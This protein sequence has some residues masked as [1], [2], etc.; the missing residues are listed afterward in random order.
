MDNPTLEDRAELITHL[1]R[2]WQSNPGSYWSALKRSGLTAQEVWPRDARAFV[3]TPLPRSE[4][5]TLG[6]RKNAGREE[7]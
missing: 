3:G 5:P 1:Q 4:T 6:K 7:S 2:L